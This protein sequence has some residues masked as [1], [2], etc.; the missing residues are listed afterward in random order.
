M[1]LLSVD[2]IY[3]EMI[4]KLGFPCEAYPGL[5]KASFGSALKRASL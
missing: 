1:G 3:I 5:G 4:V 2:R